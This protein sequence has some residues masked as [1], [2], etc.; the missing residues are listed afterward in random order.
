MKLGPLNLCAL[1][2]L[3]LSTA[4]AALAQ[5]A[6]S[7]P[8]SYTGRI[9]CADC[10]GIDATV[11]FNA[12]QTYAQRYVYVG[13]RTP[14]TF[15]E[16]GTWKLDTS[17]KTFTL[18]PSDGRAHAYRLGTNR[19]TMLGANGGPIASKLNFTLAKSASVIAIAAPLPPE[20]AAHAAALKGRTWYLVVLDGQRV[21]TA[22]NEATPRLRFENSNV[23]GSTGCNNVAGS[24]QAGAE[25]LVFSPLA[26]TRKFCAD[27]MVWENGFLKMLGEVNTYSIEGDLLK[28]RDGSKE[29][30]TFKAGP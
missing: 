19:I 15:V 17:T 8:A 16:T 6:W 12:D 21:I 2:V 30:G 1:L 29:L 25:T 13:T 22:S 10:T 27:A 5:A 18:T 28:F 14:S 11:T 4:A 9:P 7:P 3:A 20:P 24:Y 26:T 23:S